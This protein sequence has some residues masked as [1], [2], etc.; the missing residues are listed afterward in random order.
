MALFH[1]QFLL[2]LNAHK[3]GNYT[4]TYMYVFNGN[5]LGTHLFSLLLRFHQTR[6]NLIYLKN[7]SIRTVP[8]TVLVVQCATFLTDRPGQPFLFSHRPEK[9]KLGRR[10]C[11]LASCHVS[12]D[13]V[14]RFQMKSRKCLS[15][16]EARAAF[17]FFRSAR[18]NTN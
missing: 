17:L 1:F 12:L 15:Q 14:Q 9:H 11:D 5:V 13:S 4:M 7:K 2:P 16:S 10:R 8:Y 3:I 18:K 6:R